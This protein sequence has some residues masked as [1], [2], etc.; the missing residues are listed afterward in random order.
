[1]AAR[2]EGQG[3]VVRKTLT[4]LAVAEIARQLAQLPAKTSMPVDE[5]ALKAPIVK[6]EL[7]ATNN[8]GT[9]AFIDRVRKADKLLHEQHRHELAQ[10][11]ARIAETG[12][13]DPLGI[14]AEGHD[15]VSLMG[16][17][18]T[19][20]VRKRILTVHIEGLETDGSKGA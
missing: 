16:R 2:Q 13:R 4:S 3:R 11:F 12:R 14:K 18:F 5:D 15:V 8:G 1:M 17:E 10:E 19:D 20:A 9:L 7:Q 6:P